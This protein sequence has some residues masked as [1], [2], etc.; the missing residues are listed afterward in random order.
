MILS[1]NWR[2]TA[3]SSWQ[4][5]FKLSRLFYCEQWML[6]TT[7]EQPGSR[8][9][10]PG[11]TSAKRANIQNLA[12]GENGQYQTKRVW[13]EDCRGTSS[14]RTTSL[15]GCFWFPACAFTSVGGGL[16]SNSWRRWNRSIAIVHVTRWYW[17]VTEKPWKRII[18]SFAVSVYERYW[19]ARLHVCMTKKSSIVA[20]LRVHCCCTLE[21]R[22]FTSR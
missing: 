22:I 13:S 17:T 10:F 6:T 21:W 8:Y 15:L 3:K 9:I 18:G 7:Q 20:D 11:I 4:C 1:Q 12:K 2:K 14:F 16:C 5:P 19:Q